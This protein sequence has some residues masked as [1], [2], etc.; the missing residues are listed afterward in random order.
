M[1]FLFHF[2]LSIAM[3]VF[4]DIE[5]VWQLMTLLSNSKNIL[6]IYHP[7]QDGQNDHI[8]LFFYVKQW[9]NHKVQRCRNHLVSALGKRIQDL[10]GLND[11]LKNVVVEVQI[12]S[13]QLLADALVGREKTNYSTNANLV[14]PT[15]GATPFVKL[16]RAVIAKGAVR[17]SITCCLGSFSKT[18]LLHSGAVENE[19]LSS[20]DDEQENQELEEKQAE[21]LRNK[22][23]EMRWDY[24]SNLIENIGAESVQELLANLP[25]GSVQHITSKCG[26]NWKILAGQI[27]ESKA[28]SYLAEQNQMSYVSKLFYSFS[29]RFAL[30]IQNNSVITSVLWVQKFLE[31]N[32]FNVS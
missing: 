20:Q 22:K 11:W 18:Q 15:L 4:T 30:G 6:V 16:V 3:L 24:L 28:F 10:I 25:K 19:I 8:H 9:S 26:L 17:K 13:L 7:N 12:H 1:E 29:D 2:V 21:S 32:F 5:S 27:F 14:S 31:I 23:N